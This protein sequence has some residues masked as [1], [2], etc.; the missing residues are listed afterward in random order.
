MDLVAELAGQM[1][2]MYTGRLEGLSDKLG[3]LATQIEED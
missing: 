1:R 3:E 2:E